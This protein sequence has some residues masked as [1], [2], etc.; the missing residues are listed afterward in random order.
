ME[1]G[2]VKLTMQEYVEQI[3]LQKD[4]DKRRRMKVRAYPVM[5]GNCSDAFVFIHEDC[6]THTEKADAE[7]SRLSVK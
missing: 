3:G 1:G 6:V 5:Y 4:P 2:Y 7:G